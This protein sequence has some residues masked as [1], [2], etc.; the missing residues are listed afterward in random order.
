MSL[1]E[2]KSHTTIG[3]FEIRFQFP[4]GNKNLTRGHIMIHIYND[5][6]FIRITTPCYP[7]VSSHRENAF[8]FLDPQ[9]KKNIDP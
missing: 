6:G 4:H 2:R 7:H 9:N 5:M 8:H 3:T 1:N